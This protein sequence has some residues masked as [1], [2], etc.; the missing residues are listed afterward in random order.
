MFRLM[1]L[2]RVLD[3]SVPYVEDRRN[4]LIIRPP[5]TFEATRVSAGNRAKTS[6]K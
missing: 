6:E 1:A 3:E 5:E 2:S 4:V